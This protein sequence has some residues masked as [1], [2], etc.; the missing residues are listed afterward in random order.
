M[1]PIMKDKVE[2]D[3][4]AF[5]RSFVSKRGRNMDVAESAVRQSKSF[6]DQEALKQHLIEHIS[7]SLQ[8]LFKEL[9]GTTVSRFDGSQAVLHLEGQP[10][11]TLDL[12]L[13]ERILTALMDPNLSFMILIAG[14]L[15]IYAEFNFPGTIVPGTCT[16]SSMSSSRP[17]SSSAEARML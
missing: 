16:P 13:R 14:V 5:M 9:D 15:L 7:P 12:T 11:R 1:D 4:A 10:V 8:D 3:A 2:N 6:T 17:L